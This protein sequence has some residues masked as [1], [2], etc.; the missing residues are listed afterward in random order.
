MFNS[1]SA[2][3]AVGTMLHEAIQIQNETGQYFG[4]F[5]NT[6][7]YAI[8]KAEAGNHAEAEAILKFAQAMSRP[9][10]KAA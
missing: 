5:G 3:A 4:T 10:P 1:A 7:A 2:S 8:E 9:I 6:V